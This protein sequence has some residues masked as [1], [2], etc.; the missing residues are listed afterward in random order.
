MTQENLGLVD[1]MQ[2]KHITNAFD[3]AEYNASRA[4]IE[5][6]RPALVHEE[7]VPALETSNEFDI[8]TQTVDGNTFSTGVQV[9]PVHIE[10]FDDWEM[11]M[12]REQIQQYRGGQTRYN[13]PPVT[14]GIP[15][16]PDGKKPNAD[17]V[18]EMQR[19]ES[20]E[21][22]NKQLMTLQM[23]QSQ[24]Q[25]KLN[26]NKQNQKSIQDKLNTLS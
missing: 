9:N 24:L 25:L 18:K 11:R 5:N 7:G 14:S 15:N 8:Y 4:P 2:T 20:I 23:E 6:S 19:Q 3:R 1:Q 13:S 16:V 17:Q 10:S 21:H 22:L 26:R 12:Q